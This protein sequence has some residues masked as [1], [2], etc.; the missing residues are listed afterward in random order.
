LLRSYRLAAE[1]TQEELAK[2][3]S[4]SSQSIQA[5]ERGGHRPQQETAAWP[6]RWPWLSRI[7][8]ASSRG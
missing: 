7:V 4:V 3:A 6:R 1:L 8:H 5:L 2:R